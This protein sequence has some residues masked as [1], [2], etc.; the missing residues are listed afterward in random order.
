MGHPRRGI[1]CVLIGLAIGALCLS[2]VATA[3]A[4]RLPT[5]RERRGIT[6][7]AKRS[8]HA[9]SSAVH[10]GNIRVST[11]GPW[12][13]VRITIV[14]DH[15]PDSAVD[16]LHKVRG[17]WRLTKHSPGTAEVQCGIGMPRKD[18]RSL[19]LPACHPGR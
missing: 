17:V 5:R 18:Q 11:V 3:D 8:P 9:G 10:V 7:A 2:V 1:R 12:A 6:R 14:V 16:V 4:W 13:W 19:G 15:S